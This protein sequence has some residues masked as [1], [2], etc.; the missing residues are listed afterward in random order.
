MVGCGA[1]AER[2]LGD[3]EDF[4]RDGAVGEESGRE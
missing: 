2:V 3:R 1:S 4:E